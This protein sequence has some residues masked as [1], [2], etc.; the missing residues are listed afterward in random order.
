MTNKEDA[1][2][3]EDKLNIYEGN[4]KSW[5][6]LII[7][8]PYIPFGLVIQFNEDEHEAWKSLIDKYDVSDEK[9]E[10]IN[11]VTNRWNYCR[12]RDTSQDPDI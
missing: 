9:Q 3:D 6:L 2:N 7:S 8:L 10:I 11:E 1:E 5:D 12:I 4:R